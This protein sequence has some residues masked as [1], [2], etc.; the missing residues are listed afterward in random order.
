M[1][2][3]FSL[4]ALLSVV[5]GNFSPTAPGPGDSFIAGSTCTVKWDSD[6]SGRWTNVSI[7]LMSGSGDNMTY[8]TTVVNGLDGTDPTVSPYSWTCPKVAPYSSIY[9]YQFTQDDDQTD[10][11]WTSRFTITSPSGE[12]TPPEH[13]VQS[14]GAAVPWGDG[15]LSSVGSAGGNAQGTSR[16]GKDATQEQGD[17]ETYDDRVDR[18]LAGGNGPSSLEH[19][20]T[21]SKSHFEAE[22]TAGNAGSNTQAILTNTRSTS[23]RSKKTPAPRTSA[24]VEPS[25][26]A[27]V[28]T[29]PTPT[30]GLPVKKQHGSSSSSACSSATVVRNQAGGMKLANEGVFILPVSS[31]LLS[32]SLYSLVIVV[33]L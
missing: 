17:P 9:F 21:K 31:R 23:T 22:S 3:I 12:S 10:S 2:F 7:A 15:H 19:S 16:P 13:N 28:K 4:A 20:P 30:V 33:L 11:R 26:E 6:S 25:N 5:S 1:A 18:T 24:S 27:N 32:L 14:N 29:A 8:V